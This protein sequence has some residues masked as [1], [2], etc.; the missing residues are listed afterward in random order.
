MNPTDLAREIQKIADVLA[1][2]DRHFDYEAQMN[3][4]LHMALT[5]RPAPLAVAVATAKA[6]ADRLIEELTAYAG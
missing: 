2:V 6:D 1:V 4:A 3:A 5:V